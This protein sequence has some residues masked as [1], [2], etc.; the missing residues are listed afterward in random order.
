MIED[1]TSPLLRIHAPAAYSAMEGA[2]AENAGAV[3]CP[4]IL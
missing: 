1:E 3:F 2:Y 4:Y